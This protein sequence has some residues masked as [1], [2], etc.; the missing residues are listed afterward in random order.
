MNGLAEDPLHA[1]QQFVGQTVVA[2]RLPTSLQ[3]A[4]EPAIALHSTREAAARSALN[5][6]VGM[7]AQEREKCANNILVE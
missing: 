5:H 1:G 6:E 7:G 2:I 3:N 4:A